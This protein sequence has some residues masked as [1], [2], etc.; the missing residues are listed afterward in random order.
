MS[1]SW[2]EVV[3]AEA[4]EKC[5]DINSLVVVNGELLSQLM[6]ASYHGNPEYVQDLLKVQGI[7]IDLQNSDGRHALMCAS[8]LGHRHIVQSILNACQFPQTLVNLPDK[9]G[10]TTLM[11]ASMGDYT[12]IV[13]VLLQNGALIDALDSNGWSALMIASMCGCTSTVSVLIK[14]GAN[15]NMENEDGCSSLTAA[16][17]HGHDKIISILIQNGAFVGKHLAL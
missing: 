6:V 1:S 7:K 10:T 9:N 2:S 4:V 17:K 8:Q 3:L 5:S 13:L 12:E 15:V 11:I 14:N 16:V